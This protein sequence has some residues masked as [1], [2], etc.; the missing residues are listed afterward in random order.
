LNNLN[1]WNGWNIWGTVRAAQF[2][3]V[4]TE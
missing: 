2:V 3:P 1:D 4:A